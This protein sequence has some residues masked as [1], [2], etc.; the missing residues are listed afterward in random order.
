LRMRQTSVETVDLAEA[1]LLGFQRINYGVLKDRTTAKHSN[2]DGGKLKHVV[3]S[4][5]LSGQPYSQG[6]ALLF[7]CTSPPCIHTYTGACP[8]CPYGCC[9]LHPGHPPFSP[10]SIS[11]QLIPTCPWVSMEILF[12]LGSLLVLPSFLSSSPFYTPS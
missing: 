6:V 10:P 12:P 8:Q 5:T 1:S 3:L 2:W 9:D 11:C 7:L 4:H